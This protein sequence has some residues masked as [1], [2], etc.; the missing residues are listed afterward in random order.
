VIELS[1]SKGNDGSPARLV[2][3]VVVQAN[4]AKRRTDHFVFK[5]S[6][7]LLPGEMSVGRRSSLRDELYT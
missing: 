2:A 5:S 4:L 1:G 7:A 3:G 6:L